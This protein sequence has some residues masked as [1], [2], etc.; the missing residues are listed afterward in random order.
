[1]WFELS[2]FSHGSTAFLLTLFTIAGSL[3]GLFGGWMGDTLAKR[4]PNSG[5]IIL[6]QISFGSG[7]PI[8]AVLLLFLPDDPSTGFMRGLVLVIMGLCISWNPI[9][10]NKYHLTT[11]YS[12]I[13]AEIVPERS[14]TTIY[15]L[16][17]SFESILS[18]IAPPVVGLLAHH[19]YGYKPVPKEASNSAEVETDRENAASLAKALY[20]AIG[21]P[22]A[23]C[24]FIYSFLYCTY[25]RERERARMDALIES[26]MQKLE[27]DNT[28]SLEN[29]YQQSKELSEKEVIDIDIEYEGEE[30]T[31][32]DDNDKKSLLPHQTTLSNLQH[33]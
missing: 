28:P 32:L 26:E 12:P 1:M 30:S 11:G 14:R 15:A 23:I 27:P 7:I 8:A 19:V 4:L 16:D 13:F 29:Y 3:G 24:C 6:A 31:D 21:I 5:R 20:T 2:G 18:S 9:A 17:R 22:M 25:P 33:R 10:A